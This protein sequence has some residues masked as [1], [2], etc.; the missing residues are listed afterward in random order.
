MTISPR[1]SAAVRALLLHTM[2]R[3]ARPLVGRFGA[4]TVAL[5]TD[6]NSTVQCHQWVDLRRSRNRKPHVCNVFIFYVF[7]FLMGILYGC[8]YVSRGSSRRNPM[9]SNANKHP[10][11]SQIVSPLFPKTPA[12]VRSDYAPIRQ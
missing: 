11:L 9:L 1:D 6:R 10:R 4:G 12:V 3:G 2:W 5:S 7:M 8:E